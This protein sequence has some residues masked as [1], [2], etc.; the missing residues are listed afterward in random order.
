MT[1]HKPITTLHI[2]HAEGMVLATRRLSESI[3]GIASAM[4]TIVWGRVHCGSR[5]V[6]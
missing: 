3:D 6:F 2:H 1:G 5:R 4:A